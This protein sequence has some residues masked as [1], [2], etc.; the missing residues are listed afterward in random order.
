MIQGYGEKVL[1]SLAY[2]QYI[3]VSDYMSLTREEISVKKLE[4]LCV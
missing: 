3:T 4:I 2:R 1:Q